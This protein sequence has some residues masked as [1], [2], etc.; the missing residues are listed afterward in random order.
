MRRLP[1]LIATLLIAASA[2]LPALAAEDTP[3]RS[4]L[5]RSEHA[6]GLVLPPGFLEDWP[7]DA[8]YGYDVDHVHLALAVDF[9]ASNVDGWGTLTVTITEPGLLELPVDLDDAL[10][11]TAVFVDDA[12]S[13]FVHTPDQVLITLAAPLD[14]GTQH[15]LRVDYHGTPAEVGNK[16][17][18]FRSHLG[19][20]EVYA[21]STPFSNASN[22]VIPIS[23]YWRPCK[24]MPDDKS[25]FSGEFTVPDDM[26]ACANGVMTGNVDNGDGTRTVSWAHDFPVA[27]YLITVGV[28]NYETIDEVYHGSEGDAAIQHFVYPERLARAQTSFDITVPALTFFASVFGEYPYIGEKYGMFSTPTGPAVE[29]QTMVAYP[30]NLITGTHTYDWILVHEMA[31]MWFGDCMTVAD[32]RDVWLSEGPASYAEALWRENLYG[33]SAYRSYMLG[34]DDGPYAGSIYDPPYVWHAIVYD[35]AAWVMHMLRHVMGDADFFQFLLDYRAAHEHS[36]VLTPDFV[37]AAEAVYGGDLDWFFEPWLYHEGRP[38]YEYA[39]SHDGGFPTTL[40]LTIHQSQSQDY[41]TYTMPIDVEVTTTAGTET[42]VVW[43]SERVQSFDILVGAEPTGITLDRWDWILADF[44]E[45]P[46]G[47]PDR[48]AA[49]F[50]AQNLPNPFNPRTDIRFGVSK[51]GRVALRVFDARGRMLRTLLSERV[52]AGERVVTWDGR[53]DHGHDLPSGVYFYRL[54][55]PDGVAERKLTLLR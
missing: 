7:R 46:T 33:P 20:P 17:L 5:W 1:L 52:E 10:T 19:V 48:P 55:G 32:W 36:N 27:P 3:D 26:V 9:N 13:A 4:L 28:T 8:V 42:H 50:L 47:A 29:E 44:G 31:H 15:D 35:K 40:H 43:D 25:T 41:P 22:T 12:P 23:H 16:S 18:R 24:D 6:G 11:V 37:A 53:D 38:Y 54:V 51:A 21:I 30:Y 14:V 45:L 49:V 34:M 2:A 39:W